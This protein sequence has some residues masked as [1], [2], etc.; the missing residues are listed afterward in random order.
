MMKN[1]I[2]K[3]LWSPPSPHTSTTGFRPTR[4]TAAN[5]SRPSSRALFQTSRI[6]ARLASASTPF[7]AQKD[8][9]TP[10]G[11][12]AKVSSVNSGP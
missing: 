8:A 12:T 4:T 9:A 7:N 11:T 1:T 5:G 6:V 3:S 2:T 10:S